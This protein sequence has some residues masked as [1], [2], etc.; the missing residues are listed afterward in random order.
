MRSR[1]DLRLWGG[2]REAGNNSGFANH[3]DTD[4]Q[5]FVS[6]FI[7]PEY[8]F[9]IGA[10]VCKLMPGPENEKLVFTLP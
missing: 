9:A 1:T 7:N 4:K 5:L 6:V 8:F 2:G 10:K 3:R